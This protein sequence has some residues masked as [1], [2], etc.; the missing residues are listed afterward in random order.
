MR[1]GQIDG[2]AA[3]RNLEPGIGQRGRDAVARLLHR[4]IRQTDGDAN[5]IPPSAI[6]FHPDGEGFRLRSC[7]SY[8]ATS[9]LDYGGQGGA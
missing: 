9:P 7:R 3:H 1:R 4:R 6:D 8:G 2:G 5:I